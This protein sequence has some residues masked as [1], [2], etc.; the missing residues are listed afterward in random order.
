MQKRFL[1][2][3]SSVF[4]LCASFLCATGASAAYDDEGGGGNAVV[5]QNRKYN[6][7]HEFTLQVGSLP[8]DAFYKGVAATGRYTLHLSEL[9]AWEIHGSY[10]VNVE[11]DLAKQLQENFGVQP[12]TLKQVLGVVETSYVMKPMYGK[13]SLFNRTLMYAEL[14]ADAGITVSYWTDASFRP[15]PHIGGGFRIFL[16]DLLSLRL[17]ARHAVVFDGVP[18]LDEKASFEQVLQLN[19]G[20]SFN[21]GGGA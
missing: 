20:V 3:L 15:G 12:S 14:F 8:L 21:F 7:G 6:M 5:I 17:D 19:A 11:T 2:R 13:V 10:S 16:T 9:H 18:L 1:G 4:L